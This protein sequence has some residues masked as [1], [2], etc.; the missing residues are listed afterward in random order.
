MITSCS[1]RQAILTVADNGKTFQVKAGEQIIIELE[2]NPSTGY[3]WEA[4]G[5][6]T[7]L[8]RQVDDP[9]FKSSNPG[10]IGSGGSL[11]LNFKILKAG[12]TTL[13][14][15]HQRSWETDIKPQATF[16]VFVIAK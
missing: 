13:T 8:V 12:S 15:F 6:D 10:L 5:L 3:T 14:L 7:R 9:V 11:T 1:S 16:S 4:K 2:G